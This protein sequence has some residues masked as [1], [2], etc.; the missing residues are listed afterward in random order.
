MTSLDLVSLFNLR[1]EL[2]SYWEETFK[3]LQELEGK[4]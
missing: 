1:S 4:Q 3:K 2:F